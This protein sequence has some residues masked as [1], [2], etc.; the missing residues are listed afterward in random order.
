MDWRLTDPIADP[1]GTES[2][3]GERLWRLPQTA[4]CFSPLSGS[5]P[6]DP[7]PR[8]FVAFG[9]FNDLAKINEPLLAVWARILAAVPESRL[10]IK[11]RA[12]STA[13]AEQWLRQFLGIGPDRLIMLPRQSQ[14]EKHLECYAQVDVALDSYPY[15]G[16]TTTC[17]AMWMGVPVVSRA[18][19]SHVSRVGVSL[20][21]SVG[22]DEFIAPDEDRYVEIAVGLARDK[23]RRA[24]L[25]RTLRQRMSRSPLMDGEGYCRQLE[26]AFEG[27]WR[28]RWEK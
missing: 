21:H 2:I 10:I 11:N 23:A 27:M 13:F 14:A 15:H 12:S 1:P 22:L 6:T 7:A 26:A 4:W 18:G 9:S 17:E 20:L 19:A 25:R 16:T 8:D 5:P 3:G 24:E 28:E